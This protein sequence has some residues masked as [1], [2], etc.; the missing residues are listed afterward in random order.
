MG[1]SINDLNNAVGLIE[2]SLEKR[3]ERRAEELV[4]KLTGKFKNNT[5]ADA[6]NDDR[7]SEDK[8]IGT[9]WGSNGW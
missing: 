2:K 5:N 3:S 9:G 4:N 6:D 1:Y 8:K 7:P